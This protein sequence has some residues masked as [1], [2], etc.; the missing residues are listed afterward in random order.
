MTIT[1]LHQVLLLYYYLL[2]YKSIH[3]RQSSKESGPHIPLSL[4]YSSSQY[5]LS[6][7]YVGLEVWTTAYYIYKKGTYYKEVK[8]SGSQCMYVVEGEKK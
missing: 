1:S 6:F 8:K 4:L 2:P 3:K 7:I 5:F